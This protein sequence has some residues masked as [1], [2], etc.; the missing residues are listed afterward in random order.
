[1][2]DEFNF[3]RPILSLFKSKSKIS[4]T[5]PMIFGQ[6]EKIFPQKKWR[7]HAKSDRKTRC[8]A[9]LWGHRL[10]IAIERGA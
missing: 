7:P 2:P 1:M 8:S 6:K 5:S 4:L 10:P 3:N 9:P